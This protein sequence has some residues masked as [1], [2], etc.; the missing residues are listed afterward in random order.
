MISAYN[1]F[2]LNQGVADFSEEEI[3]ESEEKQNL[4]DAY[5][6]FYK[7]VV[8]RKNNN[9]FLSQTCDIPSY[10]KKQYQEDFEAAL[11]DDED[12]ALKIQTGICCIEG[13]IRDYIARYAYPLKVRDLMSTF[14]LLLDSVKEFSDVQAEIVKERISDMGK[15][16]SEK[17]EVERKK[18][19]EEEKEKNLSDLRKQVQSQKNKINNININVDKLQQIRRDMD[20]KIENNDSVAR[21]RKS[22][23][24]EVLT[25]REIAKLSGDISSIFKDTWDETNKVFN[26]IKRDYKDKINSICDNLNKIAVKLQGYNIY[27]YNFSSSLSFKKI[28]LKDAKN[29][30]SEIKNTK[31]IK[32]HEIIETQRNPIKDVEYENW[33][34][35]KK[36]GQWFAADTIEVSKT[37]NENIYSLES[38]NYYL[39]DMRWQ[40]TKLSCGMEVNYVNELEAMK[41]NAAKMADNV[42]NDISTVVETISDYKNQIDALGDNIEKLQA[43]VDECNDTVEWLNQLVD[44]IHKGGIVND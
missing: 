38:L 9:Y 36:I 25:D 34:I 39:T 4:S 24:K 2:A 27:G 41:K 3:N 28:Q 19:T 14:D 1:Y 40:L 26:K 35:F 17:E 13:A 37:V 22:S 12:K 5:D 33:Q 23:D 8:R 7:K 10:R 31:E 32:S 18:Q 43:V 20:E 29:L 6:D 30:E 42:V 11:E 16:I 15:D 21:V 44:H